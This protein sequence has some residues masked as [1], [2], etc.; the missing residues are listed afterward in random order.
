MIQSIAPLP[1]VWAGKRQ[2]KPK[3]QP[4]AVNLLNS[5]SSHPPLLSLSIGKSETI[6]KDTGTQHRRAE[7]LRR[8]FSVRFPIRPNYLHFRFSNFS[9]TRSQ[10]TCHFSAKPFGFCPA[11]SKR[12]LAMLCCQP[13]NHRNRWSPRKHRY[14][15]KS[16]LIPVDAETHKSTSPI[17]ARYPGWE[18]TIIYNQNLLFCRPKIGLGIVL[19]IY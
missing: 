17:C 7:S 9:G 15:E 18:T 11:G 1:I 12:P 2:W 3:M 16:T 14:S 19:T 5:V 4:G 10:P 13:S 8:A 6:Q